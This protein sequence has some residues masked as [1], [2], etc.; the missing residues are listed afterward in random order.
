MEE[1]WM[2]LAISLAKQGEGWVNPNPLVGAWDKGTI[3][4][5]ENLTQ[6]SMPFA[7]LSVI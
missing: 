7:A 3:S 1:K 6:R 5:M 2:R 4:G